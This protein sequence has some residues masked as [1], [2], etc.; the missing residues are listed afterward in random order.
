MRLKQHAL[1]VERK[2]GGKQRLGTMSFI[3]T[4]YGGRV[5]KVHGRVTD[6]FVWTCHTKVMSR[7]P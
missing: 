7:G 6:I 1:E 2:A 5:I 3:V 4:Q